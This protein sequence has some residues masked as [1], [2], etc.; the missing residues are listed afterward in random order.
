MTWR[1][2]I[3]VACVVLVLGT[4]IGWVTAQIPPPG[5]VEPEPEPEI[6]ITYVDLSD[7]AWAK[8]EDFINGW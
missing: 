5:Q 2:K 7:E 8:I 4:A 6:R 1:Q 3:T